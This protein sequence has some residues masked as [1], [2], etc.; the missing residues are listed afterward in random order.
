VYAYR[1]EIDGWWQRRALRVEA[2]SRPDGDEVSESPESAAEKVVRMSVWRKTATATLSALALVVA[3]LVAYWPDG[4]TETAGARTPDPSAYEQYRL[5]RYHMSK[6]NEDDIARA[7]DHFEEAARI[8]P[9]YASAYAALSDAWWVR[10]IWG[11]Q[12]LGQVESAT[13]AAAQKALAS[14]PQTAQPRVSLGRIKYTYDGDWSGAEADFRRALAI[15]P[16]SV[17]A[18]YFYAMLLMGLGRFPEAIDHI[19]H[20]A[21]LDPLSSMIQ[22]GFGRVLYR[23][24][25]YDL[26]IDR[27]HRAIALEPRNFGAYSRLGDVYDVTGRYPEALASYRKAHDAGL[28]ERGYRL[29]LAR[30]YAR[31][32]RADE[33]RRML[34]DLER[35]RTL[36]VEGAKAYAALGDVDRTFAVLLRAIDPSSQSPLAIFISEDPEFDSLHA[37]PRWRT[38][39]ARLNRGDARD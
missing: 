9:T 25:A 15:D 1:S 37:D 18:H 12:T 31:L 30:A 3:L 23:A 26:A 22:S 33:A 35:S 14:N 24:R 27:F 38:L 28:S 36:P 4:N 16:D 13:R 20:A 11:G 32:G 29:K 8:A 34:E 10:G 2:A 5:G 6:Q 19:E 17:D 7:I 21:R 39:L